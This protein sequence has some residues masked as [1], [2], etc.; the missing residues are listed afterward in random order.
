MRKGDNMINGLRGVHIASKIPVDIPLNSKEM[1]LAMVKENINEC[2]SL[3]CASVLHR[4]GIVIEGEIAI[5]SIVIGGVERV[6]H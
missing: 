3:M 6:F 5:D 4:E 1:Q 2:W